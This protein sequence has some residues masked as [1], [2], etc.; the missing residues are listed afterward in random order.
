MKFSLSLLAAFAATAFA[1][2]G[3]FDPVF[4]P[5]KNEEI[6]AG[7][8][9]EI[10]WEAPEKYADGTVSL[11]LIGGETQ[12]SQVPLADLAGEFYLSS[13]RQLLDAQLLTRAYSR[14][15]QLRREVLLGRRRLSR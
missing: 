14:Y 3:D 11:H 9:Y 2:T 7:S 6:P 8:T 10:T 15:P 12:D 13:L 5:E 4:T 1:Q